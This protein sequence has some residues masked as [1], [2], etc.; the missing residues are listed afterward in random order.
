MHA[1]WSKSVITVNGERGGRGFVIELYAERY[2]L[3]VAHCLPELPP[4][5]G[6]SYTEDRTRARAASNQVP[7]VDNSAT[8]ATTRT[9][10]CR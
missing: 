7:A 3:T 9:Q 8:C 2:V 10:C 6:M 1:D 4:A 5:H